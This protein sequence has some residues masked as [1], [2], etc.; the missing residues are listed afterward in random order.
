[1]EKTDS[2]G[3][4]ALRARV[5]KFVTDVRKAVRQDTSKVLPGRLSYGFF[6]SCQSSGETLKKMA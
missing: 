4:I 1:M 6:N 5:V 3:E 2:A